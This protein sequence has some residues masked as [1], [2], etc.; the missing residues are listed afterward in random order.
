MY[1]WD[2]NY[3]YPA[4][5]RSNILSFYLLEESPREEKKHTKK[6]WCPNPY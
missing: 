3:V 1:N 2:S 5:N 6:H 4:M